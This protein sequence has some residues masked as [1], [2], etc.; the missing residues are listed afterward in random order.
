M[1]KLAFKDIFW[2]FLNANFF[3]IILLTSNH[4]VFLVQFGVNLHFKVFKKAEIALA[5]AVPAS[6]FSCEENRN[7]SMTRKFAYILDVFPCVSKDEK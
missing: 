7:N 3:M 6:A 4:T 2:L 5:E 1:R